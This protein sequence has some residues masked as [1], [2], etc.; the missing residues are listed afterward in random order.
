MVPA[1]RDPNFQTVQYISRKRNMYNNHLY[2]ES[3]CIAVGL[4]CVKMLM[5]VL[6]CMM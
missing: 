5:M 6:F 4:N 3:L 1:A 2:I